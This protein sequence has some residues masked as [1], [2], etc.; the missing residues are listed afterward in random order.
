[1]DTAYCI[2]VSQTLQFA[3]S[4]LGATELSSTV[5]ISDRYTYKD[6]LY[7]RELSIGAPSSAQC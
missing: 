4:G 2:S 3:S 6:D 1:M 5:P 7:P